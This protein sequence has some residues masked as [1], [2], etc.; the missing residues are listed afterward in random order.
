MIPHH[1]LGKICYLQLPKI[2]WIWTSRPG[3]DEEN[4]SGGIIPEIEYIAV[5]H[6]INKV[7]T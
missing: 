3:R 5:C 6:Q 4:K 1:L 7:G 2:S